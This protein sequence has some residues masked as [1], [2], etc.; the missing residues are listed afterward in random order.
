MRFG[1]MVL[2]R[3]IS[4]I[5]IEDGRCPMSPKLSQIQLSFIKNRQLD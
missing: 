4:L 2:L 5:Q 1:L 3:F